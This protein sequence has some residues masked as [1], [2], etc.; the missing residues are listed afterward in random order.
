MHLRFDGLPATDYLRVPLGEAQGIYHDLLLLTLC[1]GEVE[2]VLAMTCAETEDPVLKEIADNGR[3]TVFLSAGPSG[4]SF[5]R[6]T[7]GWGV[8]PGDA[9]APRPVRM[10]TFTAV[11]PGDLAD[12]TL[13]A[14]TLHEPLIVDLAGVKSESVEV[15]E[16]NWSFAYTV[17]RDAIY[18]RIRHFTQTQNWPN[19]FRVDAQGE[20]G[21]AHYDFEDGHVTGRLVS[22]VPLTTFLS[23]T[24]EDAPEET[25]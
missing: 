2:L 23:Y 20:F 18:A 16:D 3:G 22:W 13:H 24:I 12:V 15:V 9:R 7:T 4:D 19:H 6:V 14:P 17:I 10:V 11:L 25:P 8:A 21:G 5:E 1:T